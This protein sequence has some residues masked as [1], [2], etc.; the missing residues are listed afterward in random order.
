MAAD[1]AKALDTTQWHK[2][3]GGFKNNSYMGKAL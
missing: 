2:Y 3:E 1:T